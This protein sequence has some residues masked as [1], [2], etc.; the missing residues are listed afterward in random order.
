[1][2]REDKETCYWYLQTSLWQREERCALRLAILRGLVFYTMSFTPIHMCTEFG[3]KYTHGDHPSSALLKVPNCFSN[4]N[5]S[6]VYLLLPS[7]T[8]THSYYL[9]IHRSH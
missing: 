7:Q 3:Q 8:P 5:A 9:S 1:M 2:G 6:L 4:S